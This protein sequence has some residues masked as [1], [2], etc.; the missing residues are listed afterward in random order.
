MPRSEP[1]AP[2]PL[3]HH[4]LRNVTPCAGST[5]PP[6]SHT[7]PCSRPG[8]TAHSRAP[9]EPEGPGRYLSSQPFP[10]PCPH[11]YHHTLLFPKGR[12]EH[13]AAF[14]GKHVQAL[15]PGLLA[16]NGSSVQ[17][18]RT[19]Q[20]RYLPCSFHA[21][22]HISGMQKNFCIPVVDLPPIL[23]CCLVA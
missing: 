6:G 11:A 18:P 10:Q 4:R 12:H 13:L 9:P 16:A 15:P 3:V 20:A 23:Q 19:T 2:R 5:T 21:L 14:G 17:T 1:S 22:I 8:N 7:D